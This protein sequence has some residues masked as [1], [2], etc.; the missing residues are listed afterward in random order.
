MPVTEWLIAV[1]PL[2]HPLEEDAPR[3]EQLLLRP[4]RALLE[5]EEVQDRRLDERALLRVDDE[6]LE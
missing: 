2:G 4:G 1:A 3:A 5:P 6:R